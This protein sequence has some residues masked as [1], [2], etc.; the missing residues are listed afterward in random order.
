MTSH[1]SGIAP[2]WLLKAKVTV[3]GPTAGYVLREALLQRLDGIVDRRF[4]ALQAPAG[5]GKTTVLADLGRRKQEEGLVVAWISL[6][7]DDTPNVFGSYL[8]YAFVCAGLDLSALN[9]PD[10][11]SSSTATYQI[12]AL[13]RA[14]DL[15]AAPCL[16]VLDEVDRLPRGTVELV[17]RLVEQGPLNLHFALAFRVNPG[18]HLAMQIFEGSGMMVGVEEFRFSRPDIDRFFGG[19][20]PESDLVAVEE[21]TAGWPVALMAHRNAQAGEA[22]R[23]G[24]ETAKLTANFVGLRLLRGLSPEDRAFV[25]DLAVF[26]WIDAALVDEVRGSS[27]ARLRIAGLSALDGLL[28]P[29]DEESA[30]LRLHPLVRDYCADLLAMEDPARKRFLHAGIA[31]ALARRGQPVPAWRHARAAGDPR[32]LG[33]L[34]ERDGVFE[35]WLRHGV[36]RLCAAAELLTPEITAL[37]PRLVLV[38]ALVLRMSRKVDEAAALYDSVAR[39]TEGFTRDRDGGDA[40]ALAVDQVFTR[41]MLAGCSSR[42]VHDELDTVLPAAGV[43]E[44]D[45]RGRLRAALR[46]MAI[47]GSCYE[48]ARF[49]ECRRHAALTKAHF[50]EER[51][52]GNIVL[53]VYLGMA[54]MAQGRVHEAAASY[55]RARRAMKKDF[56]SDPCLAVCV[57]AVTIELDLERDRKKA[58]RRQTLQSLSQLRAIWADVDAA[59]VA[60]SAELTFEQHG[61]EAAVRLLTKALDD[62][63]ALRS[64]TLSRFVSGLLVSYLVEIGRTDQ[65]AEVWREQGLPDEVVELLDADGQPWRT[66]ES[67]SCARV[68]LLAA[69]GDFAAAEEVAASLCATA[70]EHGLTR[71][72][73]RGLALSMA[74]AERAGQADHA[75]A[76]LVEFLRL[77]RQPDYVRPLVRTREVSRVVLGRLLDSGPGVDMHAAAEAMLAQL[78]HK[79]RDVP[80]FSPRELQVL[81]EVRQ[82]RQ[83]MEIAGRLGISRPGVR[84]H[85]MN[86]YRKTGVS[87]RQDAV[88]AAQALGLLD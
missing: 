51:R 20:L 87:N 32:I 63:R 34:V 44:N 46:H 26:D 55:T 75:V 80:A 21:R 84:F 70:S 33:E 27:D 69:Q 42:A 8:T 31:Q 59:A 41:V 56:F 64:E 73:L 10:A 39:K 19:D 45:E 28:A 23:S 49:E 17:Q 61:G 36:T 6:D 16:L 12:G 54:A 37:Y 5:F 50:G 38:R 66:M 13:A 58:A 86:I 67:M 85:L 35:I 71:T 29:V 57:D 7:E 81:A 43:A 4:A 18:L 14:V 78:D 9:A 68:R 11:W 3:P 76:R 25:C 52:Y 72:E 48:R 77:A 24:V 15:H 1:D 40:D 82:G 47:C 22:G 74:V 88:R 65:A 2:S 79:K 30:V 60:V 83:N 53:D 62:V